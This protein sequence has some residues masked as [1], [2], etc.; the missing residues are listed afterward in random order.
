[1]ARNVIRSKQNSFKYMSVLVLGILTT[2][3]GYLFWI[4]PCQMNT[5]NSFS[6]KNRFV[7]P[8]YT[9]REYLREF[10][11]NIAEAYEEVYVP[12]YISYENQAV[13]NL[14]GSNAS[15]V[16]INLPTQDELHH[17]TSVSSEDSS[18]L[19]HSRCSSVPNTG[20]IRRTVQIT[21]KTRSKNKYCTVFGDGLLRAT[22]GK[23]A[24][25]TVKAHISQR[26]E[27]LK[28][29]FFSV[30]AVGE[31]HIFYA[32][33]SGVDVN[34]LEVNYTYIPEFPGKYDLF[35]EAISRKSQT[36][37]P[38][39][40]FKLVVDGPSINEEE[41]RKK[42]DQLPS[43]QTLPQTDL[44]WLEGHWVTR[45]LAGEKRG[46]LRSGWVLQPNRC[47]IDIFT[48]DDLKLAASSPTL[49]TILVLGRSTERGVFLSLVDIL[50]ERQEKV[51]IT[52][53]MLWK[54]WGFME[55]RV[56]N[57]R[58]I[59]QDFRIEVA[60][61][62]KVKDKDHVNITCHNEK[63]VSSNNDFFGDAI[64]FFKETLFTDRFLPDVILLIV[65]NSMQ[66]KLLAKTIPVSW[67]GIIY[68]MNGFKSHDGSFYTID[69][70][71]ADLRLAKEIL[72]FD[73][74]FRA[75]DGF[76][77]ATPWRHATESA[78][79]I[80]SSFHWH[81]TC[82]ERDREIRV[83][84]DATEMVAQILLGKVLA[85]KGKNAWVSSFGK[86][87]RNI[88]REISLCHDCPKRLLPWHIKRVPNLKC[89]T[90]TSLL[91]IGENDIQ[92]WDGSL[93]PS[94]CMKTTPVG[95][96]DVQSG[97][98]DIR[99]CTVLKNDEVNRNNSTKK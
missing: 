42:A 18:F 16:D 41:R 19:N 5:V 3:I 17:P 57:L 38:G 31:K 30:L 10:G 89:S 25:I 86:C 33:A 45:D 11:G 58:F 29:F 23:P 87:D 52:R 98:V 88:E 39:S 81:R 55:V 80:M 32:S 93:C 21:K 90:S 37:L 14:N 71:Q 43:C 13:Y 12:A 7:I 66:I 59:Y 84:G 61:M 82:N 28:K 64:G 97:S 1:M 99:I 26:N 63:K 48:K 65:T 74:R 40:P 96:E 6:C 85:P 35:V 15:A 77:L 20:P 69:G 94:E 36:Q 27:F 95:T 92:A 47:T 34:S 78:P 68:T 76:A 50:L 8:D 4:E 79:R 24:N 9:K 91:S 2:C 67:K 60:S 83:C 44:S 70:R 72:T 22:V 73:K 51:N 75:L 56:G 54:C 62:T 53:S 49:K 46:T